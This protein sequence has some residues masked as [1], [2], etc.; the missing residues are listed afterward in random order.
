MKTPS[1]LHVIQTMALDP[2][3]RPT[4]AQVN[5]I[6]RAFGASAAEVETLIRRHQQPAPVAE[7]AQR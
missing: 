7:E 4:P 3:H 2:G 5:Q 1:T 6:A